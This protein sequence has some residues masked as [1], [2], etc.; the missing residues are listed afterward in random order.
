MNAETSRGAK[1]LRR[2]LPWLAGSAGFVLGCRLISVALPLPEVPIVDAKLAQ[3]EAHPGAYDTLFIGSSRIAFHVIPKIFDETTARSGIPTR[4]FNAAVAGIRPPE[5]AYLLDQIFARAP[6]RFRWIFIELAGLR[7]AI[8]QQTR[9]TVRALYWHDWERLTLVA[10]RALFEMRRARGKVW[11]EPERWREPLDELFDHLALF[12]QRQANVGRGGFADRLR[13]R[14]DRHQEPPRSS[15]Q[16]ETHGW[17]PPDRPVL[18]SDADRAAYEQKVAERRASPSRK[19]FGD[20]ISQAALGRMLE[21]I[22]KHGATAVLIVPPVVAKKNFHPRPQIVRLHLLLDFSAVEKFPE[23]FVTGNRIDDNHVDAEGAA[24]FT[25]RLA[26]QF[27]AE[28][29]RRQGR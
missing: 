22:E 3:L 12:A 26:E 29:E 5:D 20:P 19:D 28:F 10:R 17:V 4:S 14:P 1:L 11:K 13:A 8:P 16:S 9:H 7:T 2:A 25:K 18:T 15:F 6:G 23:L 27:V 21:K 24:I